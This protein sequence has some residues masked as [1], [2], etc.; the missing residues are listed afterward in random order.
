MTTIYVLDSFA[1][2]ALVQQEPGAE[3]VRELLRQARAGEIRLLMSLIN[4]GE[5]VYQ[6]ERRFGAAAVNRLLIRLERSPIHFMGATRARVLTAAHLKANHRLAY[7][8]AFAAGLAQEYGA[9][10]VTGDPEFRSLG[11]K[12]RVEWLGR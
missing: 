1:L 9:T 4:F 11:E 12:V 7:A 6:T 10:V 2:M 5:V 8:D 3:R